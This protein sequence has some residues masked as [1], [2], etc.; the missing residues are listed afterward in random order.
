MKQNME[1]IKKKVD[2]IN[3]SN[4]INGEEINYSNNNNEETSLD[5]RRN[6]KK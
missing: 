2:L 1:D 6:E 5:N 4:E 3:Y